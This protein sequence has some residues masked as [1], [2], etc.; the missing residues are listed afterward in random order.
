[1]SSTE[2]DSSDEDTEEDAMPTERVKMT[3]PRIVDDSQVSSPPSTVPFSRRASINGSHT[4]PGRPPVGRKA[5]ETPSLIADKSPSIAT[6][7]STPTSGIFNAPSALRMAQRHEANAESSGMSNSIP[8]VDWT[9]L[10]RELQFYLSFHHEQITYHHYAFKNDASCFLRTTLI[11]LAVSFE[12]LLYAVVGFSAFQYAIRDRTGRIQDFLQFYDRS[13]S[14]LLRHLKQRP[15][16]QCDDVAVK[17]LL[18]ILQLA[19]IEEYLGDWVNLLSHQRA[20]CNILTRIYTPS[21]IMQSDT[22]RTMLAWYTR[23][24]VFAGILGGYETAIGREWLTAPEQYYGEQSRLHPDELSY[25]IEEAI[26]RNTLNA[27]DMGTLFARRA[28]G[29]VSDEEFFVENRS[30]GERFRA[31]RSDLHPSLTDSRFAI[32]TF[33]GAPKRDPEDIVD[34]YL[35]GVIYA[36]PLW[37]MN[38]CLIDW[39]A[40][41]LMHR[42]QSSLADQ[43]RPSDDL[44]KL[45]LQ[46]CQACEAVELWPGS[47]EGTVLAT[48]ASLAMATLFLPKDARH[49]SWSRRKYANI[50]SLGFI[51]PATFREKLAMMWEEPDVL[52][53]W[54]PNRESCPTIIQS[55]RS[56]VD[57]RSREPQDVPSRDL[58]R[59]KALFSALDLADVQ[60]NNACCLSIGSTSS[61]ASPVMTV[62]ND[63]FTNP[64]ETSTWGARMR[65]SE[66]RVWDETMSNQQQQQHQHQHLFGQ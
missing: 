33:E 49:I 36:G 62:A 43:T 40:T 59:M 39:Q 6:D 10:P 16:I 45:A 61:D 34:P 56:F 30:L 35:P 9:A 20:A 11:E 17:T 31:W 57:S 7:R 22:T 12:P 1:M 8:N 3:E 63:D 27:R 19:T 24:D 51:Y 41:D 2:E 42:Y 23:F 5:S 21:S 44:T 46:I 32:T 38:F 47:V 4:A 28:K 15:I 26:A 54:L 13:V 29:A 18:T 60:Q 37:Q 66:Y 14:S 48:Q 55:I 64:L 65:A 52:D 50:E 53:W 58:K 25:K